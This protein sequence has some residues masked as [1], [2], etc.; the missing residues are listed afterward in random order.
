METVEFWRGDFGKEYTKRNRLNWRD[1]VNF[2]DHILDLTGATSVLDVGCNAGWNMLAIKSIS[3]IPMSGV[4]VNEDAIQ[5]AQSHGFDV[6]EGRADQVA[7]LFGHGSAD[8]VVTSGVLI[9]IAPDDLIPSMTAIRDVS[10]RYVLAVEY[11]SDTVQEV[12]YRGHKGRLWKRDFGKLY[13]GLGLSLEETGI[14]EGFDRCTY[15][16]F[17]K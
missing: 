6:I 17:A 15:W 8:L 4:D 13:E 2:W 11:N 12:E 14:A 3:D 10:A 1:R 9:H 16:L 5:E 7:D